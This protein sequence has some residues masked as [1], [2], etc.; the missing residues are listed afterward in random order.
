MKK[1]SI[2]S[3]AD[4]VAT[5]VALAGH[6]PAQELTLIPLGAGAPMAVVLL[7]LEEPS[8]GEAA[9]LL[10]A[11]ESVAV[12][13]GSQEFVAVVFG[14]AGAA[15]MV[16][17]VMA[18]FRP[19]RVT[20]VFSYCEG[21]ARQWEE[22][23]VQFPGEGEPVDLASHPLVAEAVAVGHLRLQTRAEIRASFAPAQFGL[24]RARRVAAGVGREQLII[25]AQGAQVAA[26]RVYEQALAP[27]LGDGA[28]HGISV[29]DE[30]A[31][32]L[33]AS[34]LDL[35]VRDLL[36]VHYTS[37]NARAVAEVWR[38]VG[39]V[40][41]PQDAGPAVILSAV[42]AW[43]DRHAA[44]AR[45]ALTVGL[46]LTPD[47]SFGRL[48]ERALNLG[49]NPAMWEQLRTAATDARESTR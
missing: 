17:E 12:F 15:D 47:H 1:V 3:P 32:L 5:A 19:D 46:E 10:A 42:C 20:P 37:G 21:L 43:V 30:H 26:R 28:E 31:A 11:L 7:P 4:A 35:E 40:L 41:E 34:A 25:G 27:Y 49:I 39:A 8:A 24:E 9:Q 44:T 16:G 2:S 23:G 29:C 14:P 36:F 18:R 6:L 48:F 38:Q 22:S 45:E 33:A 13:E